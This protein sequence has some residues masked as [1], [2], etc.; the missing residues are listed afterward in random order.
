MDN[1]SIINSFFE[2]KTKSFEPFSEFTYKYYIV[3]E[4]FLNILSSNIRNINANIDKLLLLLENEKNIFKP[5]I[6]VRVL[7]ETW[8]DTNSFNTFLPDYDVFF[9]KKKKPK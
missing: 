2:Y 6:I 9:Q 8:H 3:Q 1:I 4:R 5:N 7:T